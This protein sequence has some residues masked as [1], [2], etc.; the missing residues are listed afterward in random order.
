MQIRDILV[1]I[2]VFES[3]TETKSEHF[4]PPIGGPSSLSLCA[5]TLEQSAS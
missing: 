1:T 3:Q 2:V 4:A 5:Q